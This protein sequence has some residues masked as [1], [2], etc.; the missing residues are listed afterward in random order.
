[1][2]LWFEVPEGE[3]SEAFAERLLEHGVLVAPGSYLGLVGRGVR[4]VAL[5]PSEEECARGGRDPGARRCDAR[6]ALEIV[7]ALDR[8]ERRVAEQRDGEWVVDVEAKEAILE[9]F[10]LR[11]VEP[12]EVG[13]FAFQD[14]IPLK[15]PRGTACGSCRPAS[16]ATGRSSRRAS[17]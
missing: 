11:K 16:R 5:V 4:R 3:T 14:K 10:R 17:C 13:P 7:A 8:G 6:A 9:Y 1:M 15:R 2:Y 12:L